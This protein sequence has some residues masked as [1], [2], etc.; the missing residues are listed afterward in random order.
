MWT[1]FK[2]S[3]I[4]DR[5]FKRNVAIFL[6]YCDEKSCIKPGK[7]LRAENRRD[8]FHGTSDLLILLER[9]NILEGAV[10]LRLSRVHPRERERK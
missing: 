6:P 8:N 4:I 10:F 3:E 9:A 1:S 2:S 5:S 7:N